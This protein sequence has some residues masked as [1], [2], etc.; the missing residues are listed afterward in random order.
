V[1]TSEMHY[2]LLKVLEERPDLSQRE[3]ARELGISLG[4]VN[5]CL[6]A[7]IERGWVKARNFRHSS[8]KLGYAY[9]VT[10]RGITQKAVLTVDFLRRKV[11]EYEALERE[12]A[13]LRQEVKNRRTRRPS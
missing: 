6:A 12:I 1:V 9:L 2:R 13:H 3:L 10:P 11:E 7:L 5:Y 4:K 8:N